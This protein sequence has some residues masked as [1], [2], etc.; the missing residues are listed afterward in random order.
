MEHAPRILKISEVG[1]AEVGGKA[2]GLADLHQMG[3]SVPGAFVILD[4]REAEFPEDLEEHYAALGSGAVAVRSSAIGEDGQDASF[5]GQYAT[6]LN[7]RGV[8]GLR[9]A[10]GVCVRSLSSAAVDAYH[11]EQADGGSGRMCVVVQRMVEA[12][13]AGVL[14]TADPVSG[15]HDRLVIDAVRG[16]GESLVSGDVTPDHYVLAPDNAVLRVDLAGSEQLLQGAEIEAPMKQNPW[17]ASWCL[18]IRTMTGKWINPPSFLISSS[19]PEPC[20]SSTA[21][22]SSPNLPG[23]GSARILTGI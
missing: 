9:R 17:A 21:E 6:E 16:L 7:V 4:A 18:R 12:A 11:D 19:C 5:A 14:F 8:E 1:A 23:S 22:W 20:R 13:T 3:L 15:R 10:I 2:A